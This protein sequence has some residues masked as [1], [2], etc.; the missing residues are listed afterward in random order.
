MACHCSHP[1]E[2]DFNGEHGL[3]QMR[4]HLPAGNFQF[5]SCEVISSG[6]AMMMINS[7]YH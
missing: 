7:I 5:C 1:S 6:D 2:D 4:K 3:E